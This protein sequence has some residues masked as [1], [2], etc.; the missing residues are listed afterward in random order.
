MM[1][2]YL[3][4]KADYPDMLLFYRMGDFYEL[5]FSDAERVTKLLDITLTARGQS[6][7]NPIPMAGVPYHSVEPYLARLVKLGESIAI[8]EQ[9]SDPATSKGPVDREVVR[10][11]TP[12]T[13]TDEALLEDRRDN[14]ISAIYKSD[15]TIG[16][17][18]A[19][20]GS[21]RFNLGTI[22]H[23]D[24]LDE[25]ACLRPAEILIPESNDAL[26]YISNSYTVCKQPDWLFEIES[27]RQRLCQQ[28]GTTT[29]G[30]FGCEDMP[31][32]I[33]AAGCL[34]NYLNETQRAALPH[35]RQI[36]TEHRHD[37]VILDAATRRNLELECS[38]NGEEDK[39]LAWVMDKTATPM[40]SRLFRRWLN[41]PLRDHTILNQRYQ[42]IAE[43]IEQHQYENLHHTLKGIG[44]IERILAR[45]AL[46]SARPRD[47]SRLRDA[48]GLLPK[49]QK[50]LKPVQTTLLQSLAE[51]TGQHPKIHKL[52]SS[53]V[54]EAP[55]V[56]VRDG[57]VIK[58]GFHQELDELRALSTNADQFLIDMEERERKRSGINTLK[59]NYN[60]VHGFYIEVSRA[61]SVNVPEDYIRRQTLKASERYI[62]PELK[63]HEDKVLSARERAL[64]LEKKLYDELIETLSS[65]L[66]VLLNTAEGLSELDV[67]TNLAERAD[68]LGLNTPTLTDKKELSIEAGRHLVVEQLLEQRFVPN[69]IAL[70]ADNHTLIITG[71]NMGGKST[72]MRQVALITLLAHIGS[73]VPAS[74]ARIGM[75]DRIF[76]RIG[77]S[78]DLA[79][80]RSTFMVEMTETAN[81]LNNATE[82]SLI[83]LDEIGRGTGTYDG[84]ALAWACTEHLAKKTK[85]FTLFATHYFELTSLANSLVGLA[86]IH[87]E[88]KEHNDN[89]VFMYEVKPGPASKSYGLQVAALAG[90]PEDVINAAKA[91]LMHLETTNSGSKN[92]PIDNEPAGKIHI[93]LEHPIVEALAEI[94]PDLLS[95]KQAL[96]LIYEFKEMVLKKSGKNNDKA[97]NKKP[98]TAC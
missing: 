5:F 37:T 39:S 81:I 88:A 80:G 74:K 30:G 7:G 54:V 25:L 67:L 96:D 14:L 79:S 35:L 41:R 68:T 65:H 75:I 82:H 53:A 87:L 51:K 26:F 89:I 77:A 12:G 10:I 69:H 58:E 43:L 78:D 90:V 27:A 85:C 24:L 70:D 11:I 16:I 40:G 59:V 86:N 64:S 84:L 61:Q 6:A 44:D 28:M 73:F 45:V 3:R 46:K 36:R 2:Q 17:A 15:R 55:P 21:G 9:I 48:L 33:A 42:A 92:I 47:L 66:S 13:I 29:L 76:T 83:L 49:L 18:T 57:G 56:V 94:K 19:D 34:L 62:T 93:H 23:T 20:L 8:C 50:Q 63:E 72:Y 4:I 22:E 91:R 1:Q 38:I 95:P 98:E 32:A 60:K 31:T 52:L 97:G 71:P